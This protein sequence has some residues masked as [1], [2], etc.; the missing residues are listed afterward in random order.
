MLWQVD[1]RNSVRND[2]AISR[3][4]NIQLSELRCLPYYQYEWIIEEVMN[5]QKKR[6][7]REKNQSDG[8]GKIPKFTP[9]KFTPPTMPKVSIPKF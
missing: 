6:E 5:D 3:D 4:Y 7:E 9:P 8:I 1:I 2:I